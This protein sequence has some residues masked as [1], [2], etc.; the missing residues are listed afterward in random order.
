MVGGI[1]GGVVGG[2]GG[3]AFGDDVGVGERVRP[4]C[5]LVAHHVGPEPPGGAAR[6]WLAVGDAAEPLPA[7]RVAVA[8]AEPT[9]KAGRTRSKMKSKSKHCEPVFSRPIP[10]IRMGLVFAPYFWEGMSQFSLEYALGV[11]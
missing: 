7:G 5:L 2:V 10:H 9:A 6:G 11:H 1:V 3:E 4:A 8:P